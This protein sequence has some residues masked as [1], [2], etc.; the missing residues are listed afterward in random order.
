VNPLARGRPSKPLSLVKGHRTK[1]EKEIRAKAESAL[2]TGE[3]MK[4]WEQVKNNPIAHKEFCRVKK[5]LRTINQDDAL[6]EAVINRKCMLEAEC[7][8]FEERKIKFEKSIQE[9]EECW[10]DEKLLKREERSISSLDYIKAR[11]T[12]Q[13]HILACDKAIMTKRKMLLDIEKESIMT[14]QSALRSIPKKPKEEANDDP[15]AKLLGM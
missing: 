14:I 5:L 12:L 8:E 10:D 1:A 11:T 13:G 3:S 7:V 9:L 4:E 15:M 2:V 6:H